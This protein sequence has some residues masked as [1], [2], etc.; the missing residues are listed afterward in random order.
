M[1]MPKNFPISSYQY[2]TC[3]V[4]HPQFKGDR[5]FKL[6]MRFDLVY[7]LLPKTQNEIHLK[8]PWEVSMK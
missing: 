1:A 2:C 4:I 7:L 8:A 3:I 5:P 6:K